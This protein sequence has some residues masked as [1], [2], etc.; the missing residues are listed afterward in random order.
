MTPQ[1][2]ILVITFRRP[3]L[4]ERALRSL[5]AQQ[6]T[7]W[8]AHIVND[9]PADRRVAEIVTTLADRRLHL[10]EPARRRGGTANFNL[11]FAAGSEPFASILEDD[12]WWEPGFLSTMLA[13]LE[14]QPAA[15]VACGNERIW[16]EQPDGSWSNTGRTIWPVDAADHLFGYRAL[17]KC[18]GARLC[19]S[20]LLFR[21]LAAE[22]WRT[23]DTIPIDVTE[24]YRERAVPHPLLLVSTP[25][26][27][28]SET[29]VTNRS[30]SPSTWA[31]QQVL[32]VGSVLT[33]C[34]AAQRLRVGEALW[35]R[36]RRAEPQFAATLI[37]TGLF[38]REARVLWR[39]AALRERLRFAATAI[40]R[41]GLIR[42]LASARD[43]R[44]VEW[45]WLTSGVRARQLQEAFDHDPA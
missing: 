5:L 1:V 17:D 10:L 21:T 31:E 30:R 2:R 9:D 20:S 45:Q 39:Q 41:P 8:T 27:N 14:R 33:L 3:A 25:L 37:A 38:V 26:V 22:Q 29:L 43:R 34:P 19:N 40:R 11:A 6:H 4:L 35:C 12:N 16:R 32:L 28:Y 7:A 44:S 13:A 36:A 15:A 24:H 42:D 18:G 23:P